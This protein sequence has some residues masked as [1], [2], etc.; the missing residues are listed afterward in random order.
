M[1]LADEPVVVAGVDKALSSVVAMLVMFKVVHW[2]G[3]Q[4][5]SFVIA[6]NAVI[7][8][9]FLLRARAKVTPTHLADARVEV[10][11]AA[12]TDDVS[13]IEQSNAE[14]NAAAVAVQAV[15]VVADPVRLNFVE[16]S[17]PDPNAL[18]VDDTTPIEGT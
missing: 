8:L 12:W 4:T 10:V 2:T 9:P 17:W 3:E 13:R 1:K 7:G 6:V 14:S 11:R 5:A 18:G 15:P 16:P